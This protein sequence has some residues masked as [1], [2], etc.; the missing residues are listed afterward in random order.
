MSVG[1]RAKGLIMLLRR[2][3]TKIRSFEDE[4]TEVRKTTI[5]SEVSMTVV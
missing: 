1:E 4:R 2:E 3:V 5:F